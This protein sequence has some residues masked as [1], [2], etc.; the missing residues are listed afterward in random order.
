MPPDEPLCSNMINAAHL[1]RHLCHSIMW[2]AGSLLWGPPRWLIDVASPI[3]GVIS[4]SVN[5]RFLPLRSNTPTRSD[6][7]GLSNASSNHASICCKTSSRC[8]ALNSAWLG[9]SSIPFRKIVWSPP[10]SGSV[11]GKKNTICFIV[12]RYGCRSCL[13]INRQ[14][15]S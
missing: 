5:Y 3:T 13:S 6:H 15:H 12:H 2:E 9:L 4:P 10:F 8:T 1:S 14:C 7:H 11:S